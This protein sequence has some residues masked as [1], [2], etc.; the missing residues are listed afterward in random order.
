MRE[1]LIWRC[2]PRLNNWLF[3]R[4]RRPQ[5]GYTATNAGE[6]AERWLSSRST[7]ILS[8]QTDKADDIYFAVLSA[9]GALLPALPVQ[10]NEAGREDG[11]VLYAQEDGFLF[12]PAI[13]AVWSTVCRHIVCCWRKKALFCG[14][15]IDFSD[16]SFRAF[17][18]DMRY[19]FPR[20]E[21][22]L[23]ILEELS[24]AH[25]NTF[26]LEYE[27]RFPFT[28]YA[29]ICDPAHYSLQELKRIQDKSGGAVHRDHPAAADDW[30]FGVYAQAAT[31]LSAAGN[32]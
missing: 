27:N 4:R 24:A 28:R 6:W 30:S 22:L 7:G 20:V 12:C 17:H 13:P 23:A 9:E 8:V 16:T 31:V 10:L 15:V 2:F 25:F 32:A 11:Y 5:R 29:D 14:T 1:V 18:M 26:L 19:G 21:R 3:F